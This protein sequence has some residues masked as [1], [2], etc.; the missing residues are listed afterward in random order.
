MIASIPRGGTDVYAALADPTRRWMIRRLA[1]GEAL[2]PT[3]L[4]AELPISRQAV[5][6]HLAILEASRL[7]RSEAIGR[8]QRYRLQIEP[9]R[10]A[11]AWIR[12]IEATWDDRLAA[13]GRYLEANPERRTEN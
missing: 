3:R 6:K 1:S 7:V 10:Q 5:S 9:L 2:T 8:E 11:E 13:L 12:E 4:A